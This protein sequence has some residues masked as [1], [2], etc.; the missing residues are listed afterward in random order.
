[1]L[2]ASKV[3]GFCLIALFELSA[4]G[5]SD[6]DKPKPDAGPPKPP[7]VW[8]MMGYDANN[9]YNQPNETM[10]S[11]DT[12]PQMVEKWRFTV[13]GTP[14]GSPAIA[15][16][17]VFLM[18]TGGTFALDFDTGAELWERL[19]VSGTSSVAYADGFIYAHAATG[20]NLYKLNA[21]DGSTVWGP[22]PTY[23]DLPGADGTSSPVVADGKVLVGHSSAAEVLG[24]D[25]QMNAR[26]GVEAFDVNDGSHLWTYWTV[27]ETGENGAMVWSTVSV[28]I[29]ARVVFAAAGNNYTMGGADS[30]AIHAFSLDDGSPKWVQQVRQ[31]DVWSI[32]SDIT[33]LGEDT[34]FGA[35]PILA[36]VDGRKIVADGDKGSAFWAMDRET[37]EILWSDPQLSTMHTTNNGGVLMNGAFD[38]HYIYVASNQPGET[39]ADGNSTPESILHV[40]DPHDGSD[41]LPPQMLGATVW[42]APSLANGLLIVPAN[43]VLR[44]YNAKTGDLLNSFDTGGTIAAGA[45]AIAN[46][47]VI[48]KSGIAYPFA[49]D[50]MDN[51][52]VIAYGLGAG[53]GYVPDAGMPD[54]ATADGGG[55]SGQPTFSGV[56]SDVIQAGGCAGSSLCHG[57]DGGGHL[58]MSDKQGAY[59]AL[60]NV[61]AMGMNLLADSGPNCSASGLV[62]VKPSDPD[63]SLLV[64]K[65][66]NTQPCGTSMPPGGMLSSDQIQQVRTWI[67]NGANND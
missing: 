18:A 55:T 65:L 7:A 24:G 45:A 47:K 33:P 4:C 61:N 35:N 25:D 63:D 32:S 19:D 2:P 6:H 67:Q 9:N 23:P 49:Y 10:L 39:D 38:G 40:L 51:N 16:G 1:M 15:E 66:E 5:H 37:G 28:D 42:G 30:D 14:E 34:D 8:N 56:Y 54:G 36:E 59:D 17:K 29:D 48:V 31:D 3:S 53:D 64:K 13:Q 44:I 57:G 62:R 21:S 58:N 11:V 60:V 27:P 20:A 22:V 26:G 12:A 41:A 43:N 52:Q 50:G 46:G